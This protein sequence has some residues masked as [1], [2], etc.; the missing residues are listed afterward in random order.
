MEEEGCLAAPLH[1]EVNGHKLLVKLSLR[2]LRPDR[3]VYAVQ[4]FVEEKLGT[5]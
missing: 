4:G 1:D 2:G 5:K 3:M